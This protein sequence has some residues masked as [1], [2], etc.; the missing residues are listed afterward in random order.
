MCL[1]T[2]RYGRRVGQAMACEMCNHGRELAICAFFLHV[3]SWQCHLMIGRHVVARDFRIVCRCV[4]L[5]AMHLLNTLPALMAPKHACF[6]LVVEHSVLM[7][8]RPAA[9]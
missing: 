8:A 4:Q 9:G 7:V 3:A 2:Q 5:V 1:Q 6:L